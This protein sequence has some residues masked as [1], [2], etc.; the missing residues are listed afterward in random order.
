[1]KITFYKKK[2]RDGTLKIKLDS[3]AEIIALIYTY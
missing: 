3:L 2:R 1:M